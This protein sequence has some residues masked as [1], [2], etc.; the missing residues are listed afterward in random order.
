MT[1]VATAAGVGPLTDT[2]KAAGVGVNT[3]WVPEGALRYLDARGIDGRVFNAFHFGGYIEWRDFPRRAPIVDGRGHADGGLLEEIHFARVYP[4]A[5]PAAARALRSASGGDG[6]SLVL[7]RPGGRRAGS[8]RRC[9]AG[10]ARLGAR[11][12]GRRRPRL[13]SASR[14]PRRDH[15]A[16]RVPPGEAG[17]R[18]GRYRAAD[19]RSQSRRPGAGGARAQRARDRLVARL[20]ADGVRRARFRR[21]DRGVPAGARSRASLRGRAGHRQRVLA[22]E[23]LRG[24]DRGVRPRARHR[25]RRTDPLQRGPGAG[26]GRRRSGGDPLL[27]PSAARRSGPGARVPRPRRGV[28][29][30]RRRGRRQRSG[31]RVPGRGDAREAGS[32]C[33]RRAASGVG[34]ADEGGRRR[35]DGRPP[36]RSTQRRRAERPGLP[37]HGRAAARRGGAGSAGGAG[38]RSSL[39]AGPLG[40]RPA[41]AR[42][43]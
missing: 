40:A 43:R 37:A 14:A 26:P 11:L 10:L 16:R 29:A 4:Q 24:R 13:S 23:G 32:A 5:P 20:A 36:A 3:R 27:A 34:R 22:Q 15:R 41:R 18:R 8:G 19:R 2:R 42:P 33:R 1:V 7:R 31:T 30:H 38:R 35:S 6:L 25:D 9:G 17:Q 12:L 21:G 39:R 28:P